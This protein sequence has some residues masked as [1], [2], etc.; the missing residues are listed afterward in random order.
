MTRF[1][2]LHEN[3]CEAAEHVAEHAT[4]RT[5]EDLPLTENGRNDVGGDS[6]ALQFAQ[7][8]APELIFHENRHRG[9]HQV[10][11]LPHFRWHIEWE[12]AHHVH[13]VVILA[14][15]VATGRKETQ[16]DVCVGVFALDALNQRTALLKFAKR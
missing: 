15:F 9:I 10:D 3:A 5:E 11:E 7:V 16:H 8:V 1:L 6:P 12:V 4:P 14:H 2:V 13:L